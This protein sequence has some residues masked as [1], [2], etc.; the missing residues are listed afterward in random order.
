M[1][2]YAEIETQTAGPKAVGPGPEAIMQLAAGFMA[3]KHLFAASE[4]GLFEALADSPAGLDALA[5][6]T[7]L[8]RRA[9]RISADAMVTLGLLEA[10]D[11]IYR[12]S[13]AAA[14]YLASPGPGDLRPFLRFWDKISYPAWTRLADALASGPPQEIFELGDGLQRVASEGIEAILAQPANAL[15]TA[16]DFGPQQRLLDIGG[17]TGSWSVAV[18]RRHQHIQGTVLDVPGTVEIAR[19]KVAAAGLASRI[20]VVAGDAT[21]G[22]LPAGHDVFLIANLVHYFSP[23]QNQDLLSRVRRAARPGS[24]LLLADFWTNP[25]HTEP[26]HAALMAG[27]F[28]VHVQT[29]DVYSA[30]EART[31]LDRTGWRFVG[32]R[33]LAGPQSLIIAE[34]R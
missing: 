28:A 34:A 16:F 24:A 30:D 11:G 12:N 19:S 21:T 32:H 14:A 4:L 3:A 1:T 6:R 18:A 22:E 7:G 13:P 33:R 25:A 10:S 17:G 23:E 31:W 5:A 2:T 27:E 9:V 20:T 8:T 26:R 29:G 15:P